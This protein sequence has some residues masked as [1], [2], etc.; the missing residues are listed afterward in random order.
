MSAEWFVVV[1]MATLECGGSNYFTEGVRKKLVCDIINCV[2]NRYEK[3]ARERECLPSERKV[4]ITGYKE[5][6]VAQRKL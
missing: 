6:D 1:S 2:A 5:N 3:G 4:P